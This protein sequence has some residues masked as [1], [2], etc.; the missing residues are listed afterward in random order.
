M[1]LSLAG[2]PFVVGFWAKLFVFLAAWRAGLVWLVALGVVVAVVGLF[3]YLSI[4]RSTFIAETER[5]E[6]VRAGLGLR[7][8][9]A[10]CLLAVVGLGLQPAPLVEQATLAARAFMQGH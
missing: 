1:V 8:A 5:P 10:I 9:I 2:I 3:Y 4:A 6:P 7:A